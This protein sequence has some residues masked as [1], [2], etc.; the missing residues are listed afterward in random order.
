[1]YQFYLKK[2]LVHEVPI[3]LYEQSRSP[4]FVGME[5][6]PGMSNVMMEVLRMEMVVPQ[7]VSEKSL[8]V[9]L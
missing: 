3:V 4:E 8:L 5:M 7:L 2:I 9:P 1:M 6:S